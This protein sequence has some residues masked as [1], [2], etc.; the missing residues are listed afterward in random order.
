LSAQCDLSRSRLQALIAEGRLQVNGNPISNAAGKVIGGAVYVLAIPEVTP[1]ALTPVT[2]P[3]DIL[4]EDDH[5]LVINKQAGLTVHPA[6]STGNEPTL[7][8]AL[9]AH[10]GDS[11]SGIGGVARPGIVHRL[12]KDTSGLILVAKTDAAHQHLSAQLKDRSLSRTY[13]AF[14]WGRPKALSGTV[15]T[16][17]ARH[18]K[19]R[20]R[21]A[22]TEDGK[23]ARTHYQVIRQFSAGGLNIASEI[24]CKLETGRTHQIRVHLAHLGCPIIGDPLYGKG[25]KEFSRRYGVAEDAALQSA[26]AQCQRQALHAREIR[27][28]HPQ[29]KEEKTF[30]AHLPTDITNLSECLKSLA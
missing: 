20:T 25:D 16:F 5:L 19:I 23:Q 26:L 6:S 1:L 21:M 22:V 9:L 18:P 11:L 28:I 30:V 15:D 27:F 12:D 7:V 24:E 8:H 29:S 3:L 17:L 13:V 10:C 2:M 14:A 4:F